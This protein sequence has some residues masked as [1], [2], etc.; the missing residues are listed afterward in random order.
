MALVNVAA[1]LVRA[2]SQGACRRFRPR[3][4]GAGNVPTPAP[5]QAASWASSNIV[6]EFRHTHQVPDLRDYIYE[7]K[8]IGKK[9][10]QLWVMPAG[11]RDADLSHCSGN[12]RLE[13]ALSRG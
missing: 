4:T 5:P 13:T 8:P 6:T 2:G 3:S 12:P 10:G 1:D 7:T 9:G 11:R